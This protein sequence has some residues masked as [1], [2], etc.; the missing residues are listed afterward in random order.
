MPGAQFWAF[1]LFFTL[2]VLGFSSAFVMLDVV[3]TMIVDS[4]LVKWSRPWIVT[5]LTLTSFLMCLPYCTE[6]GY[7]L[8]DGV[9]RW[10]NNVVLIFV[11][12]AEVVSATT[13]Y[14]W[15]DT[16][17]Q[18][19]MPSFVIY[20]I[21]YFGGQF[22]GVGVA[23]ATSEPGAGVGAGIGLYVACS[24]IAVLVARTPVI[25]HPASGFWDRNKAL[26]GCHGLLSKF[27]L[28]AFYSVC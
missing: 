2:I 19:G 22:L 6:F 3:A 25:T 7:Y 1:L 4:G 21:G 9:D 11:V 15:E 20:N 16:V 13:V 18:T 26:R 12:W 24:V 14:R 10:I 17:S 5:A 8:L 28:L 23:H 27:S